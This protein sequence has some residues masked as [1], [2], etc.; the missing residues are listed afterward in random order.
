MEQAFVISMFGALFAVMN[1]FVNLPI[2]LG[3]TDGQDVASQRKTAVQVVVFTSI[4]C[5]IV[6][7]AGSAIL[8]FFGVSID[9]FRLAGGLVLGHI[10]WNMLNGED[11]KSHHGTSSEKKDLSTTESVAFYPMTFPM[12]VGPGTITTL[13]LFAEKASGVLNIIAYALVVTLVI[14]ILGVVFWFASTISQ[15]MSTT[16]RVIMTRIMGMILM[17]IAAG[18]IT[19][20]AKVLLPGLAS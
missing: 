15:H 11:N 14:G 1:P 12:L 17:A 5:V 19:E 13:I 18:M 10:G 8:S 16:M 20:G 3:L 2:F 6:A 7:L 4:M 9:A